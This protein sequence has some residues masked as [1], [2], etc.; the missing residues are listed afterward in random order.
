MTFVRRRPIVVTVHDIIPFVSESRLGM[1]LHEHRSH[2][3]VY[4]SILRNLRNATAIM[5]DSEFTRQCL[6][7]SGHIPAEKITTVYCG[8]DHSLFRP[9]PVPHEF[10]SKLRIKPGTPIILHVSNEAPHKNFAAL[11]RAFRAVVE[12]HPDTTLAKIGVAHSPTQRAAHLKLIEELRLTSNTVFVDDLTD[13]EIVYAYRAARVLVLPSLAEGFGLP[14]LEAMACGTPVICSNSWSLPEVAGEAAIIVSPQD[15]GQLQHAIE[16]LLS[17]RSEAEALRT[18][19][20]ER[21]SS[22]T[23][24]RTAKQTIQVYE[25]ASQP[26]SR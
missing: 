3:W 5:A 26:S 20:L 12:A 21:A 15:V 6:I 18:K 16:R 2:R 10:W 19:G 8:V 4:S 7:E 24:E 25:T 9:G 23:W 13:E 1:N 22:F 14:V 17:G 11:I